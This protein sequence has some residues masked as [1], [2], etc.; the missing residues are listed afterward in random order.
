MGYFYYDKLYEFSSPLDI[1]NFNP[2]PS[3]SR[4]KYLTGISKIQLRKRF[5]DLENKTA[6]EYL[7]NVCGEE[8]YKKIWEKVLE[9]KFSDYKELVCAS[10]MWARIKRVS[11]SR[12]YPFFKERQG[13]LKGGTRTLI[14]FLK[15][16][17]GKNNGKIFLRKEIE[18]IYTDGKKCISILIDDKEENF[19]C[20]VFCIPLPCL[21]EIFKNSKLSFSQSDV[22]YIGVVCGVYILSNNL[23]KNFWININ[24]ED[25]PY[26]NLIEYTNLDVKTNFGGKLVYVPLYIPTQNTLFQKPDEY[27]FKQHISLFKTLNK[28]FSENGIMKKLIFRNKYAQAICDKNFLRKIPPINFKYENLFLIDST[29]TYPQ[30]RTISGCI[31][32]AEKVCKLILRK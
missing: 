9:G 22:K 17:I 18:K 29:Q 16:E 7:K 28:S 25:I 2:L 26:V 27:F 14:K 1:L 20:F 11:S 5:K 12:T 24:R 13:Y 23:T 19:D 31:R 4:I 10:W 30:D 3:S 32:M 6:S 15:K 8:S 21:I